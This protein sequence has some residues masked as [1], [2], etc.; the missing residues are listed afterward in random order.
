MSIG[1]TLGYDA[2]RVNIPH[3]PRNAQVALYDTGFGDVPATVAD[4][5]LFKNPLHICQLDSQMNPPESD[6]IDM[7][8]FAATV[9]DVVKWYPE[10]VHSYQTAQRPGQR[11]PSVYASADN[12][13][14]LIAGFKDAGITKGPGLIIAKWMISENQAELMID[15]AIG[16]AFPVNGVQFASGQF[17]DVDL[18]LTS[19][20]DR[21][22]AKRPALFW[23]VSGP[24]DTF[25]KIAAARDA[26]ADNLIRRTV[27]NSDSLNL[28]M[29]GEA[30]LRPGTQYATV[31]P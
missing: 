17:Y 29:V 5:A 20:L 2:T 26:N 21:V 25:N 4:F 24:G 10:A 7:E 3:L 31:N 1:L 28:S 8:R 11:W 27:D 30:L 12:I 6:Y 22:S 15:D 13:P 14:S 23:Q 9:D 16:D 19:W 18:Y